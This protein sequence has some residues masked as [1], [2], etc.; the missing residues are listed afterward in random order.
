MAN[1]NG[2]IQI[3]KKTKASL[4]KGSECPSA[5]DKTT[6]APIHE[7]KKKWNDHMPTKPCTDEGDGEA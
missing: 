1:E 4:E 5:P 2:S 6:Q 3:P 7:R